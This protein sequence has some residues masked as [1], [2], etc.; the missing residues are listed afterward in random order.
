MLMQLSY[1]VKLIFDNELDKN[2]WIN[3][4]KTSNNVYNSLSK[5]IYDN[6]DIPLGLKAIHNLTYDYGRKQYPDFPA[7][8]IIKTYKLL[9]SNYKTNKRKSLCEY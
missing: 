5:I 2:Y 7:Q 8:A 3:L 4:L 9:I 1:K 6:P